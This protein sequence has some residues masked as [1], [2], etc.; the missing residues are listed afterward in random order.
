MQTLRQEKMLIF[1]ITLLFACAA[2]LYALTAQPQNSVSITL[3]PASLSLYGELAAG[4]DR[5]EQQGIALERSTVEQVLREYKNNL[6]LHANQARYLIDES[7]IG[8]KIIAKNEQQVTL[9]LSVLQ[10]DNADQKL[11]SY[12]DSVS[13]TTVTELNSFLVG[14]GNPI[15]ITK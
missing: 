12:L 8:L 2:T 1:V 11:L 7:I 10:P 14:L 5:A 6:E 15:V 3:K 13:E 4:M 9:E